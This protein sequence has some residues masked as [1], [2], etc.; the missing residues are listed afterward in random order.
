MGDAAAPVVAGRQL[1]RTVITSA[2]AVAGLFDVPR[3]MSALG[4]R[5][6]APSRWPPLV[7]F[8]VLVWQSRLVR[9]L[10]SGRVEDLGKGPVRVVGGM[11]G[12]VRHGGELGGQQEHREQH[13]GCRGTQSPECRLARTHCAIEH[14]PMLALGQKAG[15]GPAVRARGRGIFLISQLM[16]HVEFGHGGREIRMHKR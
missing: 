7:C 14:S 5:T 3:R 11:R 8:I 13:Y 6:R 2:V 10:V 1:V 16:D 9:R 12:E 4:S 15:D